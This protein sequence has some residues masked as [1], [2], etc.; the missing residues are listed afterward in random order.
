MNGFTRT[1]WGTEV[2]RP[3]P[4]HMALPLHFRLLL[5]QENSIESCSARGEPQAILSAGPQLLGHKV[6]KTA[7]P[8]PLHVAGDPKIL[9]AAL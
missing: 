6:S 3:L 1:S 4:Q 5:S 9:N 2:L 8:L 7:N